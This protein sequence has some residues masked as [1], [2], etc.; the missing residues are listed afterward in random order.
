MAIS[1]SV[2]YFQTQV[3]VFN[4]IALDPV[5]ISGYVSLTCFSSKPCWQGCGS[6]IF[7]PDS[8]SESFPSRIQDKKDFRIRIRIK[9]F[10]YFNRNT[11]E[12]HNPLF[13]IQC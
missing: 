4:K 10:K 13:N 2:K 7:I 9:D 8:R 5:S 1:T 11:C 6:G 12:L 3:E